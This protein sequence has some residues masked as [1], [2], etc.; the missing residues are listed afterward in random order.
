MGDRGNMSVLMVAGIGLAAVLGLMLIL[1]GHGSLR[2][3]DCRN[4]RFQQRAIPIRRAML[5][6]RTANR[7]CSSLLKTAET[8]I[9]AWSD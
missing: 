7:V 1:G 3:D 8:G 6:E 5:N 4:A 2:E 9:S